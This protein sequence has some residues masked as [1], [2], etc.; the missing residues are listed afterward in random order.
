M[1]FLSFLAVAA[2]AS[3]VALIEPPLAP[4]SIASAAQPGAELPP[5]LALVPADAVGFAHVRLADLWRNEVM[6]G[7]RQTWEKAGPKALAELDRQFVPAPSS[8]SRGTVFVTLDDKKKPQ[9]VGVLAFSAPFDPAAVVKTYLP[10][11]TT[12]KVGG[13]TVYRSPASEAE[14][15]F[16]DNRHIVI[17]YDGAL[18]HYLAKAPARDGPL[19]PAIRL[20]AA[21]NK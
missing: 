8:L 11:S 20:A 17:G 18:D 10:N 5:D 7:F 12:E 15:Y 9:A 4:R 14:F 16:P 1:R 21:G 3:S 13:K 2:L 6:A 19:A